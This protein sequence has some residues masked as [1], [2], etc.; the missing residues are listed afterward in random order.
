MAAVTSRNT[1]TL[2]LAAP[3]TRT[4]GRVSG[5]SARGLSQPFTYFV[6]AT[7]DLC[8]ATTV[9][10]I[11]PRTAA[12]GW[13]VTA[14]ALTRTTTQVTA[15]FDWQRLWDR[16]RVLPNGPRG[17]TELVLQRDDRVPLDFIGVA[18]STSCDAS[19]IG[20]EVWAER[21]LVWSGAPDAA[22]ARDLDG[23]LWLVHRRPDG[24]ENVQRMEIRAGQSGTG[25]FFRPARVETPT[26]TVQIEVAG[27]IRPS[28]SQN[29]PGLAIA[30][31]RVLFSNQPGAVPSRGG[32]ARTIPLPPAGD[33]ISFDLPSSGA[34]GGG[35]VV[36]AA[37]PR[38][39][40]EAWPEAVV[41]PRPG[42]SPAAGDLVAAAVA[43]EPA[44]ATNWQ[45]PRRPRPDRHCRSARRSFVLGAA[46]AKVTDGANGT[47]PRRVHDGRR[48]PRQ[49]FETGLPGAVGRRYCCDG[50][51]PLS[52]AAD[53]ISLGRCSTGDR[54][55]VV[56]ERPRH[57]R[58]ATAREVGAGMDAGRR[59]ARDRDRVLIPPARGRG[60]TLGLR[61]SV[62]VAR[63][64]CRNRAQ[65]R[66]RSDASGRWRSGSG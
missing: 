3:V 30:I 28:T 16:G 22:P 41:A 26:A 50:R 9:T 65:T 49:F 20:L 12:F 11:E 19:G 17:S 57:R 64:T 43:P 33:V 45:R 39:L 38:S 42:G 1:V 46:A 44:P 59:D 54:Q 10:A 21:Q 31:E 29:G 61:R 47:C 8:S 60:R 40:A 18:P 53:R 5:G 4:D 66:G 23:E 34:R 36:A 58:R 27:D 51:R 25:F 52:R 13:R 32:S 15:K 55:P 14:T 63:R 56:V 37:E 6:H 2:T 35:A 24:V 7:D 62:A 48:G